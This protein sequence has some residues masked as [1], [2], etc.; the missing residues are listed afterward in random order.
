MRVFIFLSALIGFILLGW[1][2]QQC[3]KCPE[4]PQLPLVGPDN[5]KLKIPKDSAE[6]QI[7]RW[8][9]M[10]DGL[11][12]GFKSPADSFILVKYF[13][14]PPQEFQTMLDDLGKDPQVWATIAIQY[15]SVTHKPYLGLIFKGRKKG[16]KEAAEGDD[17]Y[18]FT[19]PCPI[20]CD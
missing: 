1:G 9:A 8:L 11:R 10:R 19:Q 17:Y 5:P 14:I 13:K 20:F 15:D 18:D 7:D 16:G 3:P 12:K 6:A 2:C 4:C